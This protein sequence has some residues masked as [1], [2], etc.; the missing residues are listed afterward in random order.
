MVNEVYED[1][2]KVEG[3]PLVTEDAQKYLNPRQEIA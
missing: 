2:N 3:I 1:D